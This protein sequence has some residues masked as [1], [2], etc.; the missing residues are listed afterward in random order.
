MMAAWHLEI[1]ASRD[2][3]TICSADVEART[4]GEIEA[5]RSGDTAGILLKGETVAVGYPTVAEAKGDYELYRWPIG[6]EKDP[7]ITKI[8]A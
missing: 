1:R 8:K 7:I 4:V 2:G 6:E 3:R 5:V